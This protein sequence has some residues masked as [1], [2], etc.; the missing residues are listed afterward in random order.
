[1]LTFVACSKIPSCSTSASH[2]PYLPFF[3]CFISATPHCT[4][5]NPSLSRPAAATVLPGSQDLFASTAWM[6]ASPRRVFT[7][8]ASTRRTDSAASASQVSKWDQQFQPNKRKLPSFF[9]WFV[10][11]IAPI[12]PIFCE[13]SSSKFHTSLV[14][15][16]WDLLYIGFLGCVAGAK[17]VPA[18]SWMIFVLQQKEETNLY[19]A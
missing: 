15:F 16:G 13:L 19:L 2:S 10:G 7:A 4:S 9:C 14:G 3:F 8:S 18:L 5:I 1:M 17:L 12:M 11:E 6:S